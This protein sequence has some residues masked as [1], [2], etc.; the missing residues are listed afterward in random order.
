MK[1]IISAKI[2]ILFFSFLLLSNI[3]YTQSWIV[4]PATAGNW[5][6]IFPCN[7]TNVTVEMWGGGGGGGSAFGATGRA[8]GA[9]G[10]GAYTKVV[11]GSVN[12]GDQLNFTIGAGGTGSNANGVAGT[13]GGSS[14]CDLNGGSVFISNG[15][16]GGAAAN[17]TNISGAGGNGGTASLTGGLVTNSY[18]GG[19]GANGLSGSF[20]GGGGSS[21]G[22]GANGIN[23][24]NGTGATAPAG[25]GNGGNGGTNW[26]GAAGFVPGGGG[27]GGYRTTLNGTG[28]NGAIGKVR[29]TFNSPFRNYCGFTV[30]NS[31]EPI[32]NVTFAGI[33]VTTSNVINGT[34]AMQKFCYVF[35]VL[36]GSTNP[37]TLKGNTDG[38]YTNYFTVY[39]DW[40]QNGSYADAGEAYNVGTIY[41]SNGTDAVT[42]AGSIAVPATAALGSTTMRIVK[43]Y[44]SYTTNACNAVSFGQAE[45]YSVN[46]SAPAPC[47]GTPAAGIAA[48]TPSTAPSGSMV[49][50]SATGVT[51][52]SGIIYQWQVSTDGGTT[53]TDIA[54][55]TSINSQVVTPSSYNPTRYRLKVTCGTISS[56]STVAIFTP[57]YCTPRH[58]ADLLND[59]GFVNIAKVSFVGTLNDVTNTSTYNTARYQDFRGLANKSRQAQGEGMNID[60]ENSTRALIKAWVDWNKNGFFDNPSEQ[61]YSSGSVNTLTTTFG[62]QIPAAAAPGDYTIRIRVY[63]NIDDF[64]AE[65]TIDDLTPC[66]LMDNG[67]T[68]DYLFTVIPMC[69][70]KVL[71][72]S[73]G[74][75]CSSG[76]VSIP[77][78]FTSTPGTTQYRIYASETAAT[79]L[80]ATTSSTWNTP[81][82]T[83]STTYWVTAYNGT[84]ESYERVPIKAIVKPVPSVSF[85]PATASVCG[86]GAVLN[87]NATG[88]NETAYLI[89]SNFNDGT[90]GGFTS[91][92]TGSPAANLNDMK[93]QNKTSVFI[94]S[95][96]T[97]WHPAVSSGIDNNKFLYATSDFLSSSI[98]TD[99]T[100][101]TLNSTG[102]TNLSLEFD[103][104]YSHY[105]ND[106]SEPSADNFK[107]FYS[108]N[109]GTSWVQLA[110]YNYDVGYG[111]KF[112][113]QSYNLPAT[114]LNIT[115]LKIRFSYNGNW[116]DGVSIDDIK[117]Y[118]NKPLTTS[119]A[120][121]PTTGGN[122]FTDA[123]GTTP[124][125]GGSVTQIYVKPTLA[126]MIAGTPLTFTATAT[127]SNGCAASGNITVNIE[128][129]KWVGGVS[130]D[131]HTGAN[132]CSGKVP[133]SN[134]FIEIGT[135]PAGN[136]YP[137]ISSAAF[138]RDITLLAGSS[139]T[140]N[141]AGSLDVKYH[142]VNGGTLANNGTIKFTG[143]AVTQQF[144]GS[145][146]I[147]A[148]NFLEINN[149]N[150]VLL[151]KSLDITGGIKP[152]SGALNISNYNVTLKSSA[153]GTAYFGAKPAAFNVLYGSGRFTTERFIG[154]NQKKWQLLATPMNN[155]Q[156]IRDSWQEAGI[157]TNGFGTIISA[158]GSWSANGFDAFSGLAAM[159]YYLPATDTWQE[160]ANTSA[161]LK[162]NQGYFLYVRGNRTVPASA[163]ATATTA[164]LRIKGQILTGD[165][166]GPAV[167]AGKFQT[168]GNPYPSAIDFTQ[169]IS[170]NSGL[171]NGFTVWDPY[172][173]GLYGAGAYV[174]LSAA[175]SFVGTSSASPMVTYTNS[176]TNKYIQSGQAFFVNNPSA[177][178]ITPV[179]YE[180]DKT[181]QQKLVNRDE[182]PFDDRKFFRVKMYNNENRVLDGNATVFGTAYSGVLDRDDMLKV[183]N[184]AENFGL[185]V[186][187]KTLAV[188]ARPPLT[189]NDT[190]FFDIKDFYPGTYTFRFGPENMDGVPFKGILIDK[191]KNTATN[192]S[193][194]SDTTAVEFTILNNADSKASDRF[195]VIFK[196]VEVLML[197]NIDIS[198]IKNNTGS[199]HINW[200]ISS[201]QGMD[202]ASLQKSRD[203]INFETLSEKAFDPS[204]GQ[205]SFEET[206]TEAFENGTYYRIKA[207]AN[208]GELVL[209]KIVKV[210]GD[211]IAVEYAINPNPVRSGVINLVISNAET[212]KYE[213][214]V[215]NMAGQKLHRAVE[216]V[217]GRNTQKRIVVPALAAG[218][219]SLQVRQPNGNSKTLSFVA[220]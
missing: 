87:V 37:I 72:V 26:A 13:A 178:S 219:Y 192:I 22:T 181:D 49:T 15:G 149:T 2:F 93:W 20:S 205:L 67:E 183:F 134:A 176:A 125:T 51:A 69:P 162:N 116:V 133:T 129:T 197:P 60:V 27:G 112:I 172:M 141:N 47:S 94:P 130:N 36:Q 140:I 19:N 115:T 73:L 85:S 189:I 46:V 44:G 185:K 104:F 138:C 163:T 6:Y 10:G 122:L 143:T 28:G 8:A 215:L 43:N 154:V 118:G 86:D 201:L 111:T 61:V 83:A 71:S 123:A 50:L 7:A 161:S 38:A 33:S 25:G 42:L 82:I 126:Q 139:L 77:V 99:L 144:P 5:Y 137:V 151:N 90:L 103:L 200:R 107:V 209:S 148:M 64:Y 88:T 168:L 174:A 159:K 169:F 180:T 11:Y 210:S 155:E 164:N 117:L 70:A 30:S 59:Y 56:Y 136:F 211:D 150:G 147:T 66:A 167:P 173:G 216:T 40:N 132:W 3:G 196:P 199:N 106:Y 4:E 127:L 165:Q 121:S 142:F 191:Y 18:N 23:A 194:R 89:N 193:L 39:F 76:A 120:W 52:G 110:N 177:S 175:N 220:H 54:G 17:N 157:N 35:S 109:N 153:T 100:S 119:F 97:T 182:I 204:Q 188:E 84:C 24:V 31:I 145:G 78:T 92:I 195:Y 58:V 95:N 198:A 170:H 68:E 91:T 53:W 135:V 29:I 217:A 41:N 101:A 75:G 171:E 32:T 98:T 124:Y 16:S 128:K 105:Y 48:V 131:W 14:Y 186:K 79:Q 81:S 207:T 55:A 9:G 108:I 179:F 57:T 152:L 184:P 113:T 62:L 187:G 114:C 208:T 45:E 202:M 102:Y 203:G 96:T 146:T 63:N 218:K 158:T 160:V 190:I 65:Q 166:T 212:G 206:D 156:S 21:A 34:P 214:T 12:V 213:F 74:E 1:Y 80:T